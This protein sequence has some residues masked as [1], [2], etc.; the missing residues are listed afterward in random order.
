MAMDIQPGSK[1]KV[2][3]TREPTSEAAAKT[4]ARVFRASPEGRRAR[5]ARKRLRTNQS[6]GRQ[7]G[8]RIWMV[9]PKA[10]RLCQPEKGSTCDIVA[11]TSI[12]RDLESVE[13]FVK[14]G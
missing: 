6:E 3:L 5:V 8:G 9:R 11:T 14:V 4:L 2:T 1:I 7:R 13:R 12:I 10:P